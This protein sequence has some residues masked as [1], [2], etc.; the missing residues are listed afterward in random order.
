V[1]QSHDG[2]SV[3]NG[4]AGALGCGDPIRGRVEREDPRDAVRDQRGWHQHRVRRGLPFQAVD[5]ILGDSNLVSMIARTC[6]NYS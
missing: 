4:R 1:P 5:T 3:Q 6:A 2:P